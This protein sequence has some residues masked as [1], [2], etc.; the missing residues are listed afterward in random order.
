M[1]TTRIQ[2]HHTTTYTVIII[3]YF[4]YCNDGINYTIKQNPVT[5]L[6]TKHPHDPNHRHTNIAYACV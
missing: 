2:L 3:I 6:K 4:I 1:Y 5:T